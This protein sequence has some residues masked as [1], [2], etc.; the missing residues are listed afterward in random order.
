MSRIGKAPITI[1]SGVD[2]NISGDDVAVKGPKG[3]L[4]HDASCGHRCIEFDDGVLTVTRSD[5]KSAPRAPFTVCPDRSSTTWSIGRHPGLHPRNS[6]S[7]AS[8]IGPRPRASGALE[9]ALGFSH[10]V[11]VSAP[12]GIEFE[13]PS[14]TKINV[15]LGSTSSWSAKWPPTSASG[16]SPSR[17]R[18]RAFATPVS[19]LF[20][21]PARQRSR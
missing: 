5:D 19:T 4:S 13:S 7:S 18:A 9:L 14:Q 11:S 6:R 8:A 20:A 2:V 15:K 10:P 1:P 17:T 3:E 12:D 21:R 16:A